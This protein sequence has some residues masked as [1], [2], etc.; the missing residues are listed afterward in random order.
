M[1]PLGEWLARGRGAADLPPPF[2][3]AAEPEL[4]VFG[5]APDTIEPPPPPPD[6]SAREAELRLEFAAELEAER[7]RVRAEAEMSQ[8]AVTDFQVASLAAQFEAGLK[9][10]ASAIEQSLVR[11]LSP[12]LTAAIVARAH[13]EFS[14]AVTAS[15]NSGA[16]AKLVVSAPEAMARQ[17]E[18]RLPLYAG[19]VRVE[20]SE[21]FEARAVCDD[22]AIETQIGAWLQAAGLEQP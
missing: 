7:Q 15:V 20:A 16:L 10:V 21:K 3:T 12:V 17:L 18:A 6:F 14:K 22:L 9:D 11:A 8:R 13:T 5:E 1:I 4:P 2:M 19:P